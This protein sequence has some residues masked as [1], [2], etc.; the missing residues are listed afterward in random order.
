MQSLLQGMDKVTFQLMAVAFVGI[1]VP[2]S[3]LV[4]YG[5]VVGFQGLVGILLLVLAATLVSTLVS[6]VVVYR[7]GQS[8][9]DAVASMG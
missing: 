1:H 9:Q 3:V 4:V 7:L 6:L 5:I 8:R 2:L